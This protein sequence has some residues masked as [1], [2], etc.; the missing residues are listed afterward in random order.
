MR[1]TRQAVLGI[2][3]ALLAAVP[4]SA[5]TATS[6]LTG[7]VKDAQGAVLP[8]VTMTATV[9]SLIG[10]QTGCA[11]RTAATFPSLPP[12]AYVKFDLSGFQTF[13]RQASPWPGQ[14]ADRRRDDAAGDA[15]G[16]RDGDRGIADRRHQSTRSGPRWT[17]RSWWASPRRRTCGARWRSRRASRCRASTSAAATRASSPGTCVRHPGQHRVVTE[18]VDTT[19]GQ[20]GAGFYQDF[21]SQNEIA[22]SAAG[23]DVSMN[24]PGAA[25][26]STIKSGGNQFGAGQPDLRRAGVS[27]P[28]TSTRHHQPRRL[29]VAEPHVLR[30]PRRPRRP[31][32]ARTSCGFSPRTITSRSTRRSR[33]VDP[34]WRPT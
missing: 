25:V 10:S 20:G 16:K 11:R 15:P 17:P 4:L 18:G 14:D 1:Y 33:G 31:D 8:G 23:Q 5:Q 12:G 26:I 3:M 21:F 7:I 2:A 28:T 22:V 27:W 32:L 19:E 13:R 30:D 29:G 34:E 24:T 9:P 6:R